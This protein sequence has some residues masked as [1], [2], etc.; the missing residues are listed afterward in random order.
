MLFVLSINLTGYFKSVRWYIHLCKF[1]SLKSNFLFAAQLY[2][3]VMY[4]FFQKSTAV[5]FW[6]S[7]SLQTGVEFK[8]TSFC[9]FGGGEDEG[10][11]DINN[12]II[13]SPF[14]KAKS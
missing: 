13:S 12:D 11:D 3:V 6:L 9:F 5:L 2:Y 7:K 4:V 14:S 1:Y 10:D 8:F